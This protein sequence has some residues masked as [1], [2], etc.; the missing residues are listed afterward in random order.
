M[1]TLLCAAM[2]AVSMTACIGVNKPENNP[3]NT[4]DPTSGAVS[5][6]AASSDSPAGSEEAT[7]QPSAS[8]GIADYCLSLSNN[9]PVM[10][11]IDFDG[12]EDRVL[13][14]QEPASEWGD[15]YYYTIIVSSSFIIGTFISHTR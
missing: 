13:F 4:A 7:E 8:T 10:V 2:T 12:V 6:E 11:D 5:T 9:E 14:K 1:S 15:Y 3:E